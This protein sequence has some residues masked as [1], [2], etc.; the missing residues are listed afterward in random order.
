MPGLKKFWKGIGKA[1][2]I[3]LIFDKDVRND[4][5]TIGIQDTPFE[6]AFNLI[7]NSNSLFAQTV[8][9]GVMIVSPQY[10]A[11]A[12]TVSRSDDSDI[13]FVQRQSERHAGVVEEYA[14]FQ[15]DACQ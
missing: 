2:G 11:E 13:L 15:T 5:V 9:P 4:P 1:G 3:N 14:R 12:R 7:L 10:Q 8:S 6:E